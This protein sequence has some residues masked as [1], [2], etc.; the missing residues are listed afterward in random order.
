MNLILRLTLL[1][2]ARVEPVASAKDGRP[3]LW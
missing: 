2:R 1:A 3:W